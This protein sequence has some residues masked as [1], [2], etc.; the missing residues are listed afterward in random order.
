VFEGAT[1]EV[2]AFLSVAS[3]AA[4]IALL[5]RVV[6]GVGATPVEHFRPGE[7][8]IGD[9]ALRVAVDEQEE[10][11]LYAGGLIDEVE[12][13]AD[14][15][16]SAGYLPDT[17]NRA[18]ALGALPDRRLDPV[19]EFIGKL[20]AF[21]AVIT[22]TFGNL[23]AYAQTNLK[24]LLAYSTI[25][26]AGYMMMPISALESGSVFDCGVLAQRNAQRGDFRLCR[27]DPALPA[28]RNLLHA[29]S[30]QS[31]RS[32]SVVR[33]HRQVCHLCHAGGWLSTE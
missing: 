5:V 15:G 22:C 29:D 21:L 31:G 1:A 25:A 2:N 16:A 6:I 27:V 11:H 10:G 20:V 26:H 18:V 3:K 8:S 30:V 28:Y 9:S 12:S 24:R 17:E 4:A 33:F 7:R 23:A 32:A 14:S 13:P 19:R